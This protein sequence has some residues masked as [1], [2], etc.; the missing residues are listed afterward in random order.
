MKRKYYFWAWKSRGMDMKTEINR[1][2]LKADGTYNANIR[3]T[4]DR[5]TK[6]LSTNLFATQQD[7]T[8]SFKLKEDT[9]IKRKVYAKRTLYN[10]K[11]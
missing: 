10:I 7:L 11:A 6:H 5:K 2:E 4:L 3:F 1:S 9:F 8:P